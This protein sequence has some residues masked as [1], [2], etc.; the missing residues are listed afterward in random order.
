MGIPWDHMQ[1]QTAVIVGII[2]AVAVWLVIGLAL[3]NE[4]KNQAKNT[5][6]H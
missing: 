6:D 1:G 4:K 5:D 2:S 3:V